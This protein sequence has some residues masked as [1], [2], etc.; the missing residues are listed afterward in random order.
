[1]NE[2][3]A[4]MIDKQHAQMLATLACAARPRGAPKWDP[5]GVVAAL[6]NVRHLTLAEVA[7][8]VFNAAANKELRTPGAIGNT[9]SEVW[10]TEPSTTLAREPYDAFTTCGICGRAR[11]DCERNP[12]GDHD[13]ESQHDAIRNRAPHPPTTAAVE[14]D[15]MFAYFDREDAS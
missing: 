10:R 15:P 14:D 2:L 8:A 9:G 12:H 11:H 6:A 7:H 5:A 13:F 1:M 4:K 3:E